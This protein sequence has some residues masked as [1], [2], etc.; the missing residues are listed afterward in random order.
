MQRRAPMSW[1]RLLKRAF[2][3]DF[4]R[5]P[6]GGGRLKIIAAMEAPGVIARIL[7]HRGLSAR[8]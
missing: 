2:A 3:I 5:C 6:S 8:A 4:E 1:V 7:T